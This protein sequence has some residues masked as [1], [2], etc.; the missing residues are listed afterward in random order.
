MSAGRR[1]LCPQPFSATAGTSRA[2][3][4]LASK[5]PFGGGE[6][7][8]NCPNSHLQRRYFWFLHAVSR[9]PAHHP[10]HSH[11]SLSPHASSPPAAWGRH[12]AHSF[13]T[14]RKQPSRGARQHRS[15]RQMRNVAAHTSGGAAGGGGA[16]GAGAARRQR[17]GTRTRS[18]AAR[19][20]GLVTE[21]RPRPRCQRAKNAEPVGGASAKRDD[22]RVARERGREQ[23]EAA[24]GR[25][26]HVC[27]GAASIREGSSKG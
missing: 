10:G 17:G 21:A 15:A 1:A 22:G 19:A 24:V 8:R 7:T 23:R 4:R 6:L 27:G 25:D 5:R 18:A 11:S 13:P 3:I 2:D 16:A 14:R 12:I 9:F 26:E 20:A